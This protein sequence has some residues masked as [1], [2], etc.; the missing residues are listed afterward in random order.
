LTP[1]YAIGCKRILISNTY[2]PTFERE[3]VVLETTGIAS[4]SGNSVLLKDG[5]AHELDMLI[6]STGF[7]AS[8]LPISYLIHGVDGDSLADRWSGGEQAYACSTVN[9]FPNL[10]I[11]NGP[12]SGLGA[13]SIIFVIECQINYILGALKHLESTGSSRIEISRDAEDGFVDMINEKAQGTVW[14]DGGCKSWYVD[15]RNGRLTTIWPDFMSRFRAN[16]GIFNSSGY[17]IRTP[18]EKVIA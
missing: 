2:Y 7:E 16:N 11:M 5:T 15:Q 10:F 13:G 6:V 8:D 3:N 18:A 9:G 1:D 4:V 14:V 12:N 17:E